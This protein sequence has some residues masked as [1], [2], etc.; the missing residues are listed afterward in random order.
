MIYG[1]DADRDQVPKPAIRPYPRQYATEL[2]IRDG[3]RLQIRPIRPEDEGALAQFHA[4]LSGASV[5]KR[6]FSLLPL[7][8]RI[9]HER[10]L[11][12]CCID[13]D[14]QMALLAE[15]SSEGQIVGVG[16]LIKSPCRK[17]A[18]LAA[19]V[20]E[21]WQRQGIGRALV[22]GLMQFARDEKLQNVKAFV[23][24]DNGAMQKLLKDEGFVFQDCGA[25]D[26]WEAQISLD[27]H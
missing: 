7:E 4:T 27:P 25:S 24:A 10:L 6:Y 11:R 17:E 1:K 12:R 8:A 14:R 15:R 23:L 26:V 21:A 19:I 9:R 16:R 20:S 3:T 5:F 13:Y 18:E 22:R 2:V